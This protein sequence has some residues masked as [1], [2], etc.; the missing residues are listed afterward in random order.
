M[1]MGKKYEKCE[2]PMHPV[3]DKRRQTNEEENIKELLLWLLN[4]LKS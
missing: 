4:H 2:T 3:H 1:P